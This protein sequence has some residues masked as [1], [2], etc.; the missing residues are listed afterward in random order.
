MCLG[1]FYIYFYIILLPQ[2]PEMRRVSG[3]YF[4]LF[5]LSYHKGPRRVTDVSWVFF[6]YFLFTLF[7]SV[8]VTQPERK[9]ESKG[10]IED[11]NRARDA[12]GLEL[13]YLYI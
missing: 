11:N 8:S 3:I 10:E 4:I 2:R 7:T 9:G 12:T 5:L 1:Y 6:I 13:W